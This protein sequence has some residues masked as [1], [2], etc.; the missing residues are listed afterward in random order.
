MVTEQP[1]NWILLR[2]LARESAHWGEF[3]PALQHAFPNS[4][5]HPL[6]LPGTGQYY[7]ATSPSSVA[8][9]TDN[10]RARVLA[11]GL[12]DQSVGIIAVS[13]GAMVAWDW[14]QRFPDDSSAT[15][16]MNTSFAGVSPFYQRMRWQSIAKFL[17]LMAQQDIARRETD[18]VSLVS[19][20]PA[21]YSRIAEQWTAIQTRRPI[22]LTNSVRQIIAAAR[23]RPSLTT[24]QPNVLLLNSQGDRL[25][26]PMCSEAISQQWELE[27][28]T[29]PWAG[30]DLTLDASD[31][32][33]EQIQQWLSM[34]PSIA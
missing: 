22:S 8:A 34:T 30:H 7:Q 16:L 26:A 20:N 21:N 4:T 32:V 19:N 18:I 12:L 9:I 23:F 24:S 33:I 10:L 3:L 5:L 6:D 13:L 2:G 11:Q 28:H 25:V 15:V 1:T 17:S 31:W 29:H 14:R 27:L